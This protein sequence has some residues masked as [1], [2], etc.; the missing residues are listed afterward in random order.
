MPKPNK[1]DDLEL[2]LA[3]ERL[4]RWGVVG[5][6]LHRQFEFPD[7]VQAFGFMSRVAWIAEGLRHHPEWSNVY[8]TVRIDLVTHDCGGISERDVA[9]AF[10]IDAI[11]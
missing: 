4:P 5:G 8:G 11:A 2:Q 10:R 3:L 7:F 1:L 9:M 6:K